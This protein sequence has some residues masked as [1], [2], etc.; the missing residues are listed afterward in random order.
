MLAPRMFVLL[1]LVRPCW[2]RGR[3]R[4]VLA[5]DIHVTGQ[6]TPGFTSRIGIYCQFTSTSLV[7]E[8]R[9]NQTLVQK[10]WSRRHADQLNSRL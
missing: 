6:V 8:Y 10:G 4:R 5:P 3:I 7:D 9:P 1:V 2:R